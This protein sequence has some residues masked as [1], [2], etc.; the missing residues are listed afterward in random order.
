MPQL[1]TKRHQALLK[2]ERSM[3]ELTTK[4]AEIT[5]LLEAVERDQNLFLSAGIRR[6]FNGIDLDYDKVLDA[7]GSEQVK[8]L[9]AII[10]EREA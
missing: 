5:R 8:K 2:A 7:L 10:A 4:L 1:S 6:T 3:W 9:A